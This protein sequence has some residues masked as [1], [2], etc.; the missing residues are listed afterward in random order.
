MFDG[1]PQLY[2]VLKGA[3][4]IEK[5]FICILFHIHKWPYK[6]LFCNFFI[7]S[8]KTTTSNEATDV[9][10]IGTSAVLGGES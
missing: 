2:R 7:M 5:L 3:V 10:F 9:L 8:C 1:I 6:L 4:P